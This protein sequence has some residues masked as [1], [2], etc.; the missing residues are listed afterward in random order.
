[1][2]GSIEVPSDLL[3]SASI[4][5]GMLSFGADESL[6]TSTFNKGDAVD[7]MFVVDLFCDAGLCKSKSDARRLIKQGGAYINGER[8]GSFDQIVTE[9]DVKDDEILLRAGKKKYH[10]IILK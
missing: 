3:S 8:L 1:M 10:K 2:F 5:R 7:K 4:P 6:P 9:A